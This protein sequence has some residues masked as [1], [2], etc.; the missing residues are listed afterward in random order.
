MLLLFKN[1]RQVIQAETVISSL[2]VEAVVRPVPTSITSECGM[3]LEVR[4]FDYAKSKE[5]LENAGL[6]HTKAE[7][8]D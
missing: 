1:T 4:R 6:M 5:A 2:G 8:N 7:F 3:C